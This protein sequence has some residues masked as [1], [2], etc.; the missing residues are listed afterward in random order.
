[1]LISESQERMSYAVHPDHIEKFLALA[2]DVGVEASVLGEF[3]NSG[4]FEVNYGEQALAMLELEFLHEGLS[5]MQLKAHF[6]GPKKYS[7]W[8]RETAKELMP[9]SSAQGLL[10]ALK[11][12]LASPNVASREPLVR[13]YDHEVQGATRLKPYSGKTQQGASDAGVLDLSVHGGQPNNA[14]AVSNGLCPQ[15]S[16]YD[17]YLMAQ[18]SVDEA[19]RNLVATG[20]DPSRL[21]LVDNFCWPDPIPKS[22]N[23][24]AHH[25]MAQLVRACEGLYSAAQAF[26]APFVSGKDSMKNDFIGKTKSGETVKIS[27]PPTLLVTAMGQVPQAN[28][29]IPGYFQQAGDKVYLLGEVTESL[30]ASVLS[31]EFIDHREVAPEYPNLQKN[32][33]LYHKIFQSI[34]AGLLSSCHDISEGGVM[35]ALAECCFGNNLGMKLDLSKFNWS[36]LWSET[37]SLFVVSVPASEVKFFEGHFREQAQL[38]G[39]VVDSGMLEWTFAGES[40][41]ASIQELSMIWS[42]GVQDVYEA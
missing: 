38:L 27:V 41:K 12:V 33:V 18:K 7:E 13:Y 31:Q 9:E 35:S 36:Q 32:A 2:A 30:Y 11:K 5:R 3:T 6:E 39:E 28:K 19:I 40:A 21:A 34:Q 10:S 8:H 42:R 24:D 15:F 25:K 16:Y 37:G 29:V 23:P 4:F 1:M 20:A 17:T 14:V 22:S 26:K